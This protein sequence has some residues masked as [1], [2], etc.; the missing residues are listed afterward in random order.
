MPSRRSPRIEP[1][2]P[3][4]AT[5]ETDDGQPVAYGTLSDISSTGASL[6]TDV[7]LAVG[8]T[9]RFRISF[10]SPPEVHEVLG[11]V[12]WTQEALN[13]AQGNAGLCGVEWITVSRACGARLCQLMNRAAPPPLGSGYLFQKAWIVHDGWPP[14]PASDP[15]LE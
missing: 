5:V 9:L 7:H 4:T 3:I 8:S 10:A 11:R 12:V 15:S 13:G 2:C 1:P 14:P 6:G